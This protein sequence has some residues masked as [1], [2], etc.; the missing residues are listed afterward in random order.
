MPSLDEG[1]P[2][3]GPTLRIVDR[4]TLR[5]QEDLWAESLRM[6]SIVEAAFALS[7]QALCDGRP[8]LAAQVKLHEK[9]IDRRELAIENECLRVLALYEPVASDLR[10]VLTIL[11]INR[12]LER[13]GDLSARIAKRV[14][15]M[16]R[17]SGPIPISEPLEA[18]AN[19]AANSFHDAL[20]ALGRC[21][22]EAAR[23]ILFR[24][25]Q[26]DKHRRTVLKAL[27]AS[28]VKEPERVD[29][30]LRLMNIAR[31]LERIGDHAVHIAEA[32]VYLKEG[33]VIRHAEE[34]RQT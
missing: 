21:D 16:A 14:K 7:I 23:A 8:D 34:F 28:L 10:R 12:D 32:V 31:N 6:A 15:R 19:G 5:V 13:V 20:D 11:R 33:R 9:D 1:Q 24:D 26:I 4:P 27:K 18:L 22:A 17:D 29:V 3:P 2:T 30:W 25:R